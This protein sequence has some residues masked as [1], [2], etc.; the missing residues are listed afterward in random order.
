MHIISSRKTSAI[1][2]GDKGIIVRTSHRVSSA[3]ASALL[4]LNDV[5]VLKKIA[6]LQK[7]VQAPQ[8]VFGEGASF[9]FGGVGYPLSLNDQFSCKLSLEAGVF[10]YGKDCRRQGL[11]VMEDWYKKQARTQVKKLLLELCEVM[12]V[13]VA[14]IRITNTRTRWGSCSSRGTIS[15]CWRLVMAPEN[16]L[17]YV[18]IHEL[19]HLIHMNHSK[20][21]WSKVEKVMPEY[22]VSK[23]WLT[24]NG[25]TISWP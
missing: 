22:R 21:F 25:V 4:D 14:R 17:R 2:L 23:D 8:K 20:R 19:V 24:K 9:F 11:I 5:W 13:S 10:T 3:K 15:I 1:E 16:V 6:H 7:H 18:V 12:G